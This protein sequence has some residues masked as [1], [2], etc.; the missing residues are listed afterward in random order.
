MS[1]TSSSS[2]TFHSSSSST[3]A[4]NVNSDLTYVSFPTSNTSPDY[5]ESLDDCDDYSGTQGTG[6]S[7]H[8]T[9]SEPF[10]FD[11]NDAGSKPPLFLW[12]DSVFR[13]PLPRNRTG[14]ILLD[15]DA[16]TS[17][18]TAAQTTKA[19]IVTEDRPLHVSGH[20]KS[21]LSGRGSGV[22]PVSEILPP[23]LVNATTQKPQSIDKL[24]LKLAWPLKIGSLEPEN[25][26]LYDLLHASPEIRIN[27]PEIHFAGVYG[28]R[29]LKELE[30]SVPYPAI[31]L[32][33]NSRRIVD[34]LVVLVMKRYEKL[35]EAR[36]IEEFQS[37]FVDCVKCA[38]LYSLM[39]LFD[40]HHFS[41]IV[42]PPFCIHQRTLSPSGS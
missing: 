23:E 22:Y 24:V 18:Q 10:P 17:N 14:M 38:F 4:L 34:R 12:K 25:Q 31:W 20:R 9:L 42:R 26:V 8:S 41:L 33:Q 36:S 15:N 1:P 28:L 3:S 39:L 19:Y 32:F 37:V 6:P 40:I 35:W 30:F 29:D 21:I 13:L 7:F 16:S 11:S 5:G 27:L 2:E